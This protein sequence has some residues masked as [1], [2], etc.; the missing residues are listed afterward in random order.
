MIMGTPLTIPRRA[1][2]VDEF[3]KMGEAG[4]LR[5]DDRI[6]LIGGELIQMSPIS[7]PQMQL[8]NLLSEMLVLQ[9]GP[10]VVVSTQ[11]PVSLPPD[12]EPQPHIA[13]FAPQS[14]GVDWEH[15][16]ASDQVVAHRGGL[17]DTGLHDTGLRPGREATHL[18]VPRDC[19]SMAGGRRRQTIAI[20]LD[21]SPKG[22]RRLVT[23]SSNE[24]ISPS[25]LP[26]VS[27]RLADLWYQP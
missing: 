16:T 5:E 15:L 10:S 4:I 19:G 9:L 23:P 25:R 6:E 14:A 11:K 8:V 13:I 21:P 20:Y 27:V 12:N 24:T 1:F 18:S 17:H 3:H 7:G 2:T 22:Y 26:N